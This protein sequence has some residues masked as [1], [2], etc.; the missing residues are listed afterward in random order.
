MCKLKPKFSGGAHELFLLYIKKIDSRYSLEDE[1]SCRE[2][3]RSATRKRVARTSFKLVD[4]AA[5]D[6]EL[7]FQSTMFANLK[8]LDPRFPPEPVF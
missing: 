4:C 5:D 1:I 6:G 7:S 2:E 3:R 8:Q